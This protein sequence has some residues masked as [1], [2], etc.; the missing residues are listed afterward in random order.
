MSLLPEQ[1]ATIERN[2]QKALE[3]KAQKERERQ[4]ETFNSSQNLT[5][6]QKSPLTPASTSSSSSFSSS[7]SLSPSITNK[8][9]SYGYSTPSK[10]GANKSSSSSPQTPSPNSKTDDWLSPNPGDKRKRRGNRGAYAEYH[11]EEL[12]NSNGGFF[13][14]ADL[15]ET[16]EQRE[17]PKK[18]V[19]LSREEVVASEM[20]CVDCGAKGVELNYYRWFNVKTC[21]SCRT[22]LL[23]YSL[24]TKTEAQ[25]DYLLTDFDLKKISFIERPNPRNARFHDMKLYLLGEVPL[26]FYFP[27]I[28]NE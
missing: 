3:L 13:I 14:E 1:L 11:L 26:S 27:I 9:T 23:K 2:R 12:I 22:S 7:S 24:V 8:T 20:D 28:I 18:Y 16:A 19:D 15:K 21:K 17:T 10:S 4:R 6:N 5:P 25:D